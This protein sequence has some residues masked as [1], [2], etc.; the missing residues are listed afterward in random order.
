MQYL[1]AHPGRNFE[2]EEF[3][4]IT[5]NKSRKY[6]LSHRGLNHL[7]ITCYLENIYLRSQA[8]GVWS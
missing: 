6:R 8:N 4:S 2:W 5:C 3:P 7:W 1:T